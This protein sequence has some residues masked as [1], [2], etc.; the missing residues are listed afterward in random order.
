[1]HREPES[2]KGVDGLVVDKPHLPKFKGNLQMLVACVQILLQEC[3][4]AACDRACDRAACC[5]VPMI[6]KYCVTHCLDGR[7][8]LAGKSTEGTCAACAIV[9]RSGW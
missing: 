5:S 1:M 7:V 6:Q 8:R 2:L 4:R 3:D 9:G